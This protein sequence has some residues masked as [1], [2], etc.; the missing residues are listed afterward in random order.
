M[1]RKPSLR[2]KRVDDVYALGVYRESVFS[3]G[4]TQDDA[5][6]LQAVATELARLKV[7]VQLRRIEEVDP[8]DVVPSFVF[9]MVQGEAGLQVL[10]HW[11]NRGVYITN[12]VDAVLNCR[13]ERT[14]SLC[15]AGGIPMPR[16]W[17]VNT[18]QLLE[19]FPFWKDQ[20]K[21]VE[22]LDWTSGIW[23]KRADVHAIQAEDVVFIH[24][25]Q[26]LPAALIA[27]AQRGIPR[28]LLQAHCPGRVV[29]F[30]GV[31]PGRFFDCPNLDV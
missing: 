18:T 27:F 8:D 21:I 6:I 9:S 16:S 29:K 5:L 28:V 4:R 15:G 31:G 11:Q 30:Y 22:G 13:R 24:R 10:R 12:S 25:E 1:W 7:Q 17:L 23:L 14:I 3:P 19:S 26:E 20:K 2:K